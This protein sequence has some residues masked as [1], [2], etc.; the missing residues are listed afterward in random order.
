MAAGT[1][2][3]TYEDLASLPE[4]GL[5]HEIISGN[6]SVTPSPSLRHQDIVLL[7]G[8][9]ILN[10]LDANGGG[11]VFVAPVDVRITERDVVVPDVVFVAADRLHI[12]EGRLIDGT[13]SLIIEVVSDARMDR[14]R[15]RDLYAKA[16]VTEYWIADP[17]ADRFE[18][19][20]S[21]G[22]TF[23]KPK[24]LE[25]GEILRTPLIPG[26]EIDVATLLERATAD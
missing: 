2:S 23:A 8:R 1:E 15:K 19:Y 12:L 18:I 3:L 7:L 10:H 24:I 21:E 22:N 11:R 5:R 9:A 17:E 16:G 20:L 4:D 6:H 26:L 25:P 14:V 13:P